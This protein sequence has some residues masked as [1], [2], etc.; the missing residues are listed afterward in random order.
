MTILSQQCCIPLWECWHMNHEASEKSV[1]I[2]DAFLR[3]SLHNHKSVANPAVPA[4]VCDPSCCESIINLQT[5]RHILHHRY[6]QSKGLKGKT[7]QD[8]DEAFIQ[9]EI[10]RWNEIRHMVRRMY[11]SCCDCSKV[12][13]GFFV[14]NEYLTFSCN[15]NKAETAD[16]VEVRL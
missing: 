9:N 15:N 4:S 2:L 7:L 10:I 8:G 3:I 1:Q 11:V 5:T 12:E 6:T 16:R 13:L 14:Y